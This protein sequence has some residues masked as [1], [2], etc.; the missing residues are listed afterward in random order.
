MTLLAPMPMLVAVSQL[1]HDCEG[2]PQSS[3]TAEYA[4]TATC[5]SSCRQL[6]QLC[7]TCAR[8]QH[9]IL[10]LLGQLHKAAE[11]GL[12]VRSLVSGHC[13]SSAEGQLAVLDTKPKYRMSDH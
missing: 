8:K 9:C 12:F 10:E 4:V 7:T 1:L 3:T 6:M 11:Q 5:L 2:H 13:V